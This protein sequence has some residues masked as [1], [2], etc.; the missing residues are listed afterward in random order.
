MLIRAGLATT[1]MPKPSKVRPKQ[2]TKPKPKGK[3]EPETPSFTAKKSYWIILTAM[4]VVI[5][6]VFGVLFGLGYAKTAML[7]ATVAV[8]IGIVGF[9]RISPSEL[10]I[11]KRATFVFVGA[12]IIG[13]GIW[14]VIALVFMPVIVALDVF[15][16]V[17][18]LVVCL[19]IGG[20]GGE[21]LGRIR[22]V[23]ERLFSQ[24]L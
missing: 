18:S 14:A 13:F 2:K 17:T 6:A 5:S 23:Q 22:R 15:F 16:V 9:I 24:N 8:L 3:P 11:S 1:V 10:S 19:A 4:F 20:L 21:L 7:A 12:S